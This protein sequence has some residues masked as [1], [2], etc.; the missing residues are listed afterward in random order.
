MTARV[1]L[2]A[3]LRG[4][5]AVGV[6]AGSYTKSVTIG[7]NMTLDASLSYD[8]DVQGVTGAAAGL[9]F[10]W[11]CVQTAPVVAAQCAGAGVVLRP[12]TAQG[13]PDLLRLVAVSGAAGNTMTITVT[14]TDA[15]SGRSSSAAASVTASPWAH[16]SCS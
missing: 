3:P 4:G 13:R 5:S 2:K 15:S 14:V 12:M 11:S 16:R 6:I 10:S 8:Q 7:G 9:S 1:T